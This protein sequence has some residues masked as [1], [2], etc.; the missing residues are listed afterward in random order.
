MPQF[1]ISFYC[2][3]GVLNIEK[4]LMLHFLRFS[5]V[6]YISLTQ[7]IC[8]SAFWSMAF[9]ICTLE[10]HTLCVFVFAQ[11]L[12]RTVISLLSAGSFGKN[13]YSLVIVIA[14]A[15]DVWLASRWYSLYVF[16]AHITLYST[17]HEML[18]ELKYWQQWCGLDDWSRWRQMQVYKR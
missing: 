5:K 11:T 14:G 12:V 15:S 1:R 2:Y 17:Y 8:T 3:G 18:R 10:H 13:E 16:L 4:L 7:V 6:C 9:G